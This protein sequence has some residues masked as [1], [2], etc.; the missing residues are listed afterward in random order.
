MKALTKKIKQ[1]LEYIRDLKQKLTYDNLFDVSIGAI[2]AC[3]G[4][5]LHIHT[6][7]MDKLII[8]VVPF[9]FSFWN[10]IYNNWCGQK[11]I[12]WKDIF[13][14]LIIGVLIFIII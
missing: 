7:G 6:V 1:A 3:I 2:L 8:I 14:R 5:W 11:G 4:L 10:E 13:F 9:L 12:M